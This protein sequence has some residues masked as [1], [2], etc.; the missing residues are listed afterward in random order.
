M[1]YKKENRII[2]FIDAQQSKSH[3]VKHLYNNT[4]RQLDKSLFL[5]YLV[6]ASK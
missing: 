3:Q 4:G 1:E 2:A 6:D 5:E